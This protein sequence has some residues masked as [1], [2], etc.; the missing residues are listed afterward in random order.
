MQLLE[1]VE[2]PDGN[3]WDSNQPDN[4]RAFVKGGIYGKDENAWEDYNLALAISPLKGPN[5]LPEYNH[6]LFQLPGPS[7]S[8]EVEWLSVA[9]S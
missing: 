8:D 5:L 7:E 6:P 4:G 3:I 9:P 2:I 1:Y